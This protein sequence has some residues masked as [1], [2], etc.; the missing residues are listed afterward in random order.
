[1]RAP[2]GRGAALLGLLFRE[3]VEQ[4]GFLWL[5][6]FFWFKYLLPLVL[7]CLGLEVT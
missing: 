5:Y 3:A 1:M 6:I 2:A 4:E 7:T